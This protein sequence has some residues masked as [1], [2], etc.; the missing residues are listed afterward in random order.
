MVVTKRA[1]YFT[2]SQRPSST[3]SAR[4]G[5]AVTTIPLGGDYRHVAGQFN[6]NIVATRN[7]KTLIAVQSFARKLFRSTP[8][9]ESP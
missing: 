1:A 6:L 3:R 5:S 4:T 8:T 7:G 9:R 2:D